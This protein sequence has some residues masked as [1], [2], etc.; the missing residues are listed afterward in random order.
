MQRF[1]EMFKDT[2]GAT[3]IEYA[4]IMAMIFLAIIVSVSAVGLSTSEAWT[5]LAD[6]LQAT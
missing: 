1:V 6:T 4:L 3:A 5:N 2:R